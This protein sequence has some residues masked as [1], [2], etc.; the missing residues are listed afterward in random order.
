MGSVKPWEPNEPDDIAL[1]LNAVINIK[2][3][4]SD[5]ARDVAW[6]RRRLEEED[7][8]EEEELP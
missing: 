5:V 8:D 3:A 1:I 2:G 6:I 7:G 4:L